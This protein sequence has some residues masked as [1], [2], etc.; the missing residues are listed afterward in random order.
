MLN[1]RMRITTHF[2]KLDN[3]FHPP[4]AMSPSLPQTSSHFIYIHKG[5]S[6]T[7][8]YDPYTHPWFDISI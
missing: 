2:T 3:G 1:M 8:K 5:S 4:W 7:N 6:F